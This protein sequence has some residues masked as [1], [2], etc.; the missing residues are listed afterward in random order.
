MKTYYEFFRKQILPFDKI[1][2]ALPK[3]GV[4]LDLGCGQGLI[5]RYLA[6][7]GNRRVIG[8]DS[9]IYRLPKD[10]LPNLTYK[11]GDI[12]KITFGQ[13]EGVVISD[14][15]HHLQPKHQLSL[16]SKI[17]KNLKNGGVLVIKEIDTGEFVRSKLSRL[18]DW[19][20]YPKDKIAFTNSKYMTKTLKNLGFRVQLSR[21]CRLFPGST[22]LYICTKY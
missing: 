15:L 13:I 12:T 6:Q 2:R 11:K 20:L 21:P 9:N 19:L 8:I 17:H 7:Q 22:T 4:I 5:A 18:W 10:N 3:T 14:V 1:D 16:L